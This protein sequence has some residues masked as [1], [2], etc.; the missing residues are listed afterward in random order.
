MKT[1]LILGC[2]FHFMCYQ[3][4]A[5]M[6]DKAQEGVASSPTASTTQQNNP[7]SPSKDT[8]N[9]KYPKEITVIQKKDAKYDT[10]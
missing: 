7:S 6:S 10:P 2:L 4:Y 5:Q 8:E 1:L 9:E 3:T